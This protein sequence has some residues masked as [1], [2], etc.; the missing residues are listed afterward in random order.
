MATLRRESREVPTGARVVA[1]DEPPRF[2]ATIVQA[3]AQAVDQV[4]K[5]GRPVYIL[6]RPTETGKRACLAVVEP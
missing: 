2:P 6:D 1:L 5:Y 4:R 3:L